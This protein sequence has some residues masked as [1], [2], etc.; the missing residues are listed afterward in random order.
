L[1]KRGKQTHVELRIV[2]EKRDTVRVALAIND[3]LAAGAITLE[4]EWVRDENTWFFKP[5][6]DSKAEPSRPA[7]RVSQ[8]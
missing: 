1:S 8:K 4:Q 6:A 3:P 5:M 2:D 7:R